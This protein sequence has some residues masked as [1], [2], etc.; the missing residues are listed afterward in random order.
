MNSNDRSI[1]TLTAIS[2]GMVHTYELS[3]PIFITVWL[4]EFH[5]TQATVGTLAMIGYLLFG[6]GSVPTGVA[7]DRFDSKMLLLGALAGMGLAFL[8]IGMA[9]NLVFIG[10]A[11]ALWGIAASIH[12]PSSLSLISRAVTARGQSLAYHGMMGNLGIAMGPFLTS[13]LLTFL[14]WRSVAIV[15]AVPALV[16]SLLG[17]WI[18]VDEKPGNP[19]EATR[20]LSIGSFRDFLDRSGALL[21]SVYGLLFI[22][23]V[24]EGLYYRG[25]LTFLPDFFTTL[26]QIP[27]FEVAGLPFDTSKYLY[28]AMLVFGMAGQYVGGRLSDHFNPRRTLT[29]IFGL[30]ALLAFLFV[31]VESYSFG[32]IIVLSGLTGLVLFSAQ[33]LYQATIA[34]HTPQGNRGLAYGF[35]F[36]GIF[37]VGAVGA[38]VAGYILSYS[39]P[40]MLF[41]VLA[42]SVLGA[43][44]ML[45]LIEFL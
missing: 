4:E 9:P 25:I 27:S 37:G 12:H 2:H 39:S 32:T 31:P 28:S 11:F 22:M 44:L 21:G 38:A 16:I 45:L 10:G 3:I 23:V 29:I 6:L 14:S 42:M 24:F 13:L 1:T 35:T 5:T 15:L 7:A 19:S 43:L 18:Q 20:D 26:S 33:P 34:E 30:L 40:T 8:L 36:L 17:T 41:L